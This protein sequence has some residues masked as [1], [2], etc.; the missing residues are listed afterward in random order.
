MAFDVLRVLPIFI[1]VFIDRQRP[2]FFSTLLALLSIG[3]FSAFPAG[4]EEVA[5]LAAIAAGLFLKRV[6]NTHSFI[7][8]GVIAFSSLVIHTCIMTFSWSALYTI[9][10]LDVLSRGGFFMM[11]EI[12]VTLLLLV[13]FLCLRYSFGLMRYAFLE[14]K[15]I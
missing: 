11:R 9:A 5:L 1:A 4:I 8:R 6:L 13:F 14:E 3:A 2:L 15:I 10:S 12:A 7:S